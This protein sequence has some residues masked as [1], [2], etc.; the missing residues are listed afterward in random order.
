M[1]SVC[2]RRP[3]TYGGEIAILD[4][5][6]GQTLQKIQVAAKTVTIT[7]LSHSPVPGRSLAVV[8]PEGVSLW[9]LANTGSPRLNLVSDKPIQEAL[10]SFDGSRLIVRASDEARVYDAV[11]GALQQTIAVGFGQP[12]SM[13]VA[14]PLP[15]YRY[16]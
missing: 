15:G 10:F 1:G 9:D 7:D 5:A 11:S 6:T 2:T 16:K 14:G 4:A 3:R 12:H 8:T 13:A